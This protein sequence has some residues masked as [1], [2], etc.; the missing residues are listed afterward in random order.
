MKQVK[1]HDTWSHYTGFR[2]MLDP[3]VTALFL[4]VDGY[5]IAIMNNRVRCFN[6]GQYSDLLRSYRKTRRNLSGWR[7]VTD[8]KTWALPLHIA[9]LV[10]SAIKKRYVSSDCSAFLEGLQ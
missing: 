7:M 6:R 5:C 1:T 4:N 10:D 3:Q 8:E 2:V 9:H